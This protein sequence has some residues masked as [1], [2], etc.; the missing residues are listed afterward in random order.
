MVACCSQYSDH[1]RE[2]RRTYI[3]NSTKRPNRIRPVQNITTNSRI[4]HNNTRR[5]DRILRGT[6]QLLKNQI[7]HL[8]QRGV[9]ILE[10]LRDTEEE[11]GSLVRGKLLPGEQEN[12]DLGQ[13]GAACPGR[14]GG[15]I[16]QSCWFS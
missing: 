9:L 6:R 13:E 7:H 4:L 14:D 15:G 1:Q 12:R 3:N 5:H 16:E 2:L 10:Q 11:R 8:S